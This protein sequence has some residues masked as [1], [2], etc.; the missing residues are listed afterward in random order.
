M[1]FVI[2]L[3]YFLC[4]LLG[5]WRI[6]YSIFVNVLHARCRLRREL[7]QKYALLNIS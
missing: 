5:P 3:V 7:E 6:C 1:L 4:S 2:T